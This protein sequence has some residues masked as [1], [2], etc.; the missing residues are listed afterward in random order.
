MERICALFACS[1]RTENSGLGRCEVPVCF[2]SWTVPCISLQKRLFRTGTDF[3]RIYEILSKFLLQC[4]VG[5]WFLLMLFSC[6]RMLFKNT[7]NKCLTS[8]CLTSF[9]YIGFFLSYWNQ[10][11]ES[12]RIGIDKIQ[13]IPNPINNHSQSQHIQ[14]LNMQIYGPM[15]Y[16]TQATYRK[17][18]NIQKDKNVSISRV[19]L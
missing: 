18:I 16:Q 15:R 11:K 12:I 1:A 2:R 19:V 7:Q 9:F 4:S 5:C 8:K 6:N 14:C 3:F 10:N 13:T 17:D